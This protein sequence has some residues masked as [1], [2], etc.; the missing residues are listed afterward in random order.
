MI[1]P[2]IESVTGFGDLGLLAVGS[3][4]FLALCLWDGAPSLAIAWLAALAVCLALTGAAKL[5]CMSLYLSGVHPFGL[6]LFSP[7]GHAS[8]SLT[9]YGCIA[10]AAGR[11]WKS[12]RLPLLFVSIA[13]ALVIGLTRIYRD[14]HSFEEVVL[15]LVIGTLALATFAHL[16]ARAP[17]VVL[18]QRSFG[19]L[20]CLFAVAAYLLG[21]VHLSVEDVLIEAASHF[22]MTK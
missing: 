13:F 19:S 21:G 8:F 12:L 9:F 2:L 10:H 1:E 6:T 4:A 5:L 3:I 17:I 14:D 16:Q 11:N 22:T 7:S 15:G 20:A 18:P